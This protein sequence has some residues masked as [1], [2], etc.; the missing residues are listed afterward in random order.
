MKTLEQI[1]EEMKT[2]AAKTGSDIEGEHGDADAL[3]CEALKL[4]GQQELVEVYD[5]IE[6]W[7]A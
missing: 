3:L 6:K 1:L 2:I 4:F 7:Y 5:K